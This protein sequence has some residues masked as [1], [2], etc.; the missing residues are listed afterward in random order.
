M[1][2]PNNLARFSRSLWLALGMFVIFSILFVIYVRSEKQLDRVNAS[3]LQSHLLA[4]ELRQS[5]DDLTR[6]ARSYVITGSPIY[7][8]H[9]QDILDIRDGNFVF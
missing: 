5:S 6:M 2:P 1:R 8:Q 4:D 7:K 9:F 3:R